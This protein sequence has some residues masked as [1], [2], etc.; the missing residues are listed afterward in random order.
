MMIWGEK[1]VIKLS[2]FEESYIH[3][4]DKKEPEKIPIVKPEVKTPIEDLIKCIKEGKNPETD[5]SVIEK[6]ALLS[7]KVYESFNKNII[8]K[9]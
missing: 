7:D 8:A 4:N 9:C 2:L 1:G 3:F 6:V 5:I